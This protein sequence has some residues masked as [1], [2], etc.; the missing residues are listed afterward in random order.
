[1]KFLLSLLLFLALSA[2]VAFAAGG[3]VPLEA[4]AA[5]TDAD[6]T[7]AALLFPNP[8]QTILIKRI[9]L[10]YDNAANT[11]PVYV[12][13]VAATAAHTRQ[14]W[15]GRTMTSSGIETITFDNI[16][17]VITPSTAQAGVRLFISAASSDSLFAKV[18]YE[19]VPK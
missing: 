10:W 9:T 12:G 4:V 19:I 3:E 8:S 15:L 14:L 5:Q 7:S 1:M 18:E 2:G 16:N 11:N 17:R 6:T 13:I